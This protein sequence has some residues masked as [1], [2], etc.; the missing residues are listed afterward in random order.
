MKEQIYI[1]NA[2]TSW[3]KPEKVYDFMV[4]FYRSCGINPGRS[5]SNKAVEAE[6]TIE[7]LRKRLTSFF[8]GDE[9]TPER[10]CFGYNATDSLN[11]II[12]GLLSSG[13][14]VVTTNLE[15]NSVIRPINHLVQ[16]IGVQ[17]TFVPFNEQGFVEP[18]NIK[19]SIKSNTKLVIVNHGSNVLGTIQPIAE[20]GAICREAGVAFAIDVSQTAGVVPINMKEMNIDVLAFTGHKSLMGA[21]G[22]GGMCVR[23]H[24]DIR[25]TRSGGSGILSA[26]PFHLDEYPYRMEYGTPNIVGI[27]SL[28]AGLDWIDEKGGIDTIYTHEMKLAHKLVDA[29][30]QTDGVT[31]YCCDNL[32]NHLPTITMNID[33]LEADDVGNMLDTD[34]NIATRTGL[35]CAPLVHKQLGTMDIHGAVRFS[36]GPFNTEEHINTAIEAIKEISKR[37]KATKQSAIQ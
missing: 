19:K 18:D 27:A 13:D 12:Q 2:S 22:I 30:H 14:H 8:G 7:D 32:D 28:W 31:T 4:E 23:K 37:A 36:I 20:I 9:D 15:H 11:L 6:D 10:L 24:L 26:S 17:A 35:H 5:G 29:F 33:K 25:H 3:P 1:D 34:Y 16:D 21:T